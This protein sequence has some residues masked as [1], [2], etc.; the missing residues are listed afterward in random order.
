MASGVY[1]LA[2]LSKGVAGRFPRSSLD[3]ARVAEAIC[4][5]NAS[6]TVYGAMKRGFDVTIASVALALAAL[7]MLLIALII[8]LESS[9]PAL[10]PQPRVGYRGRIFPC[11][12]FRTMRQSAPRGWFGVDGEGRSA[13]SPG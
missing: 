12:K 8:R 5:R 9:G 6:D 13:Q 2:A 11:F 10:L 1:N 7:P 4:A 3:A